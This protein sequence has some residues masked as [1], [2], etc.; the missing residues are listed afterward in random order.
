M[1][2]LTD[3]QSA[4]D[5]LSG[6]LEELLPKVATMSDVEAMGRKLL[7]EHEARCHKS[8]GLSKKQIAALVTAATVVSGALATF[9][10]QLVV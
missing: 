10:S 3:L 4:F 6:R 1:T 2:Q 8:S 9:L 5:K 7:D